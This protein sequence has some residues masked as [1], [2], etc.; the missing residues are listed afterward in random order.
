MLQGKPEAQRDGTEWLTLVCSMQVDQLST[1]QRSDQQNAFRAKVESILKEVSCLDGCSLGYGTL[2][3]ANLRTGDQT[4]VPIFNH[5]TAFWFFH[6]KACHAAASMLNEGYPFCDSWCMLFIVLVK[7]AW[8]FV[9]DIHQPAVG[10][11]DWSS[12]YWLSKCPVSIAA[13]LQ[14]WYHPVDG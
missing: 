1:F 3:R 6:S 4:G 8:S 7:G 10:N 2:V 12:H 11:C 14:S 13:P 5:S 9:I